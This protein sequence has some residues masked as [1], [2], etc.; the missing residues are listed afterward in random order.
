MRYALWGLLVLA[1]ASPVQAAPIQTIG[2]PGSGPCLLAPPPPGLGGPP[3]PG[4]CLLLP[5][6]DGFQAVSD[7]TS[8][9]FYIPGLKVD[10]A[11]SQVS[12]TFES[13]RPFD[14]LTLTGAFGAYDPGD[15]GP[16]RVTSSAGG[17]VLFRPRFLSSSG[18][19]RCASDPFALSFAGP[20]WESLSSFTVAVVRNGLDPCFS[21]AG[22]PA[23]T[24]T[25]M[26][27]AVP[28][29][30]MLFLSGLAGFAY[31]WRRA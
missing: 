27:V 10:S 13:E 6:G 5:L 7:P 3:F 25:A 17:D 23:F 26:T 4:A 2:L 11:D 19:I 12:V 1:C 24:L 9:G 21:G 18:T 20:A 15:A 16:F 8:G 29:P 30:F 28:E 14:L 22:G 31:W